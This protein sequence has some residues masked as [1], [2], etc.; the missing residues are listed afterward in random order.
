MANQDQTVANEA[1]CPVIGRVR[2]GTTN[3][4]WWPN[5]LDLIQWQDTQQLGD[6]FLVLARGRA[7]LAQ[8]IEVRSVIGVDGERLPSCA[9]GPESFIEGTAGNRGVAQHDYTAIAARDR[10]ANRVQDRR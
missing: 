1:Q 10:A 4:Q 7:H 5:R 9:L 2:R 6:V 3:S 8:E